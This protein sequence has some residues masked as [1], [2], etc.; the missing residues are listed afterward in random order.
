MSELETGHVSAKANGAPPPQAAAN[1][2]PAEAQTTV[3]GT[4]PCPQCGKPCRASK[5]AKPGATHY[6]GT[7]KVDGAKGDK[8][9]FT[10]E[11]GTSTPAREPGSDD[12]QTPARQ[13]S[14]PERLLDAA[15][16]YGIPPELAKLL[17]RGFGFQTSKDVTADKLDAVLEMFKQQRSTAPEQV[18]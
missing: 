10:F 15:R 4:V 16:E 6:C 14:I 3:P 1:G 17:L 11:P 18:A 9:A 7:C 2:K 13:Q 8:I 5:Y 12:G